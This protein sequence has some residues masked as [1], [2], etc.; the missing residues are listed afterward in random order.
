MSTSS[1]KIVLV[2]FQVV[3]PLDLEHAYEA[4]LR[5]RRAVLSAT[6]GLTKFVVPGFDKKTKR[7]TVSLFIVHNMSWE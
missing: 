1:D 4:E 7:I 2:H 3:I 5:R 6:Q